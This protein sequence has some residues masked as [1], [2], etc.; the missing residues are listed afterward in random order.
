M[1]RGSQFD[2]RA[3]PTG[4]RAG[5]DTMRSQMTDPLPEE[6]GR[7]AKLHTREGET[8]ASSSPARVRVRVEAQAP[9]FYSFCAEVAFSSPETPDVST[10]TICRRSP[11]LTVTV[12]CVLPASD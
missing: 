3:A 11:R 9:N 1:T 12:A 5:V 7:A 6:D 8:A 4:A 2:Y 10:S